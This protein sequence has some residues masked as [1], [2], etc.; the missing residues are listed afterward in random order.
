[1]YTSIHAVHVLEPDTRLAVRHRSCWVSGRASP[2]WQLESL[3]SLGCNGPDQRKGRVKAGALCGQCR[4]QRGQRREQ[5]PP[6]HSPSPWPSPPCPPPHLRAL[7]RRADRIRLRLSPSRTLA[8]LLRFKTNG[9]HA[10]SASI[11]NAAKTRSRTAIPE[12]NPEDNC[13]KS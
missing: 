9:N 6:P 3:R 5:T 2:D 1:M 13:R 8:F 12:Q 4:P 10:F 7:A 11:Y